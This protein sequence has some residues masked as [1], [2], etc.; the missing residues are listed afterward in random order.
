M[1][2]FTHLSSKPIRSIVD[3]LLPK[4]CIL[5][6]DYTQNTPPLCNSCELDLPILP[7][8]CQQCAQ[9]LRFTS[10]NELIC[11]T[12][13]SHAPAFN[14]T[15][16]LFPYEPP[17]RQLITRLKFH[18]ELYYARALGQLMKQRIQTSWYINKPFP[19]L[20]IPIP[21]HSKRLRERGFNQA[22]EIAKPIAEALSIP[23]DYQGVTRKKATTAQSGLPA[24]LRKRNIANAF[25]VS[26]D[27]TG[28]TIALVDDVMT[29]GLTVR[30][31]A[32]LLKKHGAARIEVWCCA[33]NG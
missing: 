19:N 3:W 5:C 28:L 10:Q 26:R 11:G 6:N 24:D 2:I 30:E 8:S 7:Q 20:I 1:H 4:T 21:L 22:L 27:Y 25:S 29:T 33:R 14:L 13:L 18:G 23:I 17:I 32:R 31:C 16:A 15:H 9:F 12:C